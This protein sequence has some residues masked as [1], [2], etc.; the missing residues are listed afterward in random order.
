MHGSVF[1]DI[2]GDVP[3]GG[4]LRYWK[5]SWSLGGE[6]VGLHWLLV[7]RAALG[8][9]KYPLAHKKDAEKDQNDES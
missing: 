6:L 8:G 9:L 7:K 4:I 5:Y 2:W 1:Q 3:G